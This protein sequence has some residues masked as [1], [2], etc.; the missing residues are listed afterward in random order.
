[1]AIRE[2]LSRPPSGLANN[3]A[4]LT[5]NFVTNNWPVTMAS[6]G[7]NSPGG[8]MNGICLRGMARA[9][10]DRLFAGVVRRRVE[11]E[12][13]RTHYVRLDPPVA[14]HQRDVSF[15]MP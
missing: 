9:A 11:L 5:C 8:A 7:Q 14:G 2:L 13:F 4:Y 10:H 3:D 1:M 12:Q 6:F 15:L